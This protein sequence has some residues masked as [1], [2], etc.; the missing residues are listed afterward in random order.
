MIIRSEKSPLAFKELAAPAWP[1]NQ[2]S[3][4]IRRAVREEGKK[5]GDFF[6]DCTWAAGDVIWNQCWLN[7]TPLSPTVFL[8]LLFLLVVSCISIKKLA[9]LCRWWWI[10]PA[11]LIWLELVF[12]SFHLYQ[13]PSP[14]LRPSFSW[15]ALISL[16]NHLQ[17]RGFEM[18]HRAPHGI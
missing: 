1:E 11:G 5:R 16:P 13:Y 10:S 8:L 14:P 2:S 18:P 7:D 12:Y 4:H 9:A 15:Q 3:H 6:L 17:T